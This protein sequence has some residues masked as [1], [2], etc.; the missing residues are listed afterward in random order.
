MLAAPKQPLLVYVSDGF[1]DRNDVDFRLEKS[2]NRP[3]YT[4]GANELG[5]TECCHRRVRYSNRMLP[6]GAI[7]SI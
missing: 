6:M 7:Q 3:I 1:T 5:D 4:I 2:I